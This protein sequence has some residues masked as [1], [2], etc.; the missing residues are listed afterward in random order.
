MEVKNGFDEDILFL[1]QG[2]LDNCSRQRLR[3]LETSLNRYSNNE[4]RITSKDM[5]LALQV[6]SL[7]LSLSLS[8]PPLSF[9]F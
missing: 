1:L 7:S 4:C 6:F 3:A 2:Q 8:L 5:Q 9:M